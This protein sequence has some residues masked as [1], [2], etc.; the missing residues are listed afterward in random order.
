MV[1]KKMVNIAVV[2]FRLSGILSS[3]NLLRV[4]RWD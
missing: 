4:F 3:L 2:F 1:F